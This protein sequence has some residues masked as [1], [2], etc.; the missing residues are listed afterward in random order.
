MHIVNRGYIIV[1]HKQPF[2]DWAN[3]QDAEFQIEV[4]DEGTVYLIDEDFFDIEPLIERHYKQIFL[5]EV[6]GVYEDEGPIPEFSMEKFQDWFSVDVG[7]TVIDLLK[8]DL[9]RD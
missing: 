6:E 4:G 3:T 2:V 5:S 8:E 9:T 7:G 1:T